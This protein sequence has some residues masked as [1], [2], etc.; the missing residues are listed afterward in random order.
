MKNYIGRIATVLGIATLPLIT[1]C[2]GPVVINY[3]IEHDTIIYFG[4]AESYS[5]KREHGK[6]TNYFV[7]RNGLLD[8]VCD[9][10]FT[11]PNMDGPPEGECIGIYDAENKSRLDDFFQHEKTTKVERHSAKANELVDNFHK[12]R[13]A[14]EAQQPVPKEK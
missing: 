11:G 14:W 7:G 2:S 4:F 10:K 6:K 5:D 12:V 13:Q 8:G 3:P 1:G 9:F